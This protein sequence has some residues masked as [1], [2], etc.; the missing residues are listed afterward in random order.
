MCA[1]EGGDVQ[2]LSEILPHVAK[3]LAE[4]AEELEKQQTIMMQLL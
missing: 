4:A 3:Q 1:L 2:A